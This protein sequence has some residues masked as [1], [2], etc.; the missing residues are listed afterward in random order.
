MTEVAKNLQQNATT[1][2]DGLS[3]NKIIKHCKYCGKELTQVSAK[4]G[5]TIK[6]FPSYFRC[7]CDGQKKADEL[8]LK[9]QKR[10]LELQKAQKLKEKELK[11]EEKRKALIQELIGQS[12]LHKKA[13]TRTFDSFQLGFAS[14]DA[15]QKCREY[16]DNFHNIREIEKNGL[17]IAGP[18]GVGK[19]HLAYA[20]AN[21][22]IKKHNTDVV[23]ATMIEL[24]FKLKESFKNNDNEILNLYK[25]CSLLIID[26]LG[27]ERPTEWVASKIYEIIDARANNIKPVIVTTNYVA[28][29]LIKK[30]TPGDDDITARA[31]VDRLYEVCNYI[32]MKGK[33]LR[34][35][36]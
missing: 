33:S 36:L 24:L 32:P 10:L 25:N 12:G 9:E 27:K 19:S 23:C 4:I 21:D 31:T 28:E 16:V 34:G 5:S 26:D 3:N 11:A 30:M 14:Q 1:P 20:I 6:Y 22:L 7:D 2:M 35:R 17:F 8:E 29:D 18:C 13:L 15:A